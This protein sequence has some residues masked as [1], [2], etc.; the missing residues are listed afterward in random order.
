MVLNTPLYRQFPWHLPL[1]SIMENAEKHSFRSVL[2]KSCRSAELLKNKLY[3]RQLTMKCFEIFQNSQILRTLL[4]NI[5]QGSN[6]FKL[7]LTIPCFLIIK[8]YKILL[9]W[10]TD[11]Q[12]VNFLVNENEKRKFLNLC[13]LQNQSSNNHDDFSKIWL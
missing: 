7:F 11:T 8:S 5:F 12:I 1:Q 3:H 2:S 6:I 13:F 4:Q 10:Y 9:R